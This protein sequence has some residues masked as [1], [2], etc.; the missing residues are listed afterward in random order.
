M[1]EQTQQMMKAGPKATPAPSSL[2][3]P[4]SLPVK[5]NTAAILREEAISFLQS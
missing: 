1:E 3:L 5:L 2:S 4:P